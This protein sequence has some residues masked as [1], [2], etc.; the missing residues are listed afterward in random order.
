MPQYGFALM[1]GL[2]GGARGRG[3]HLGSQTTDIAERT[4]NVIT[5]C[6]REAEDR[7]KLMRNS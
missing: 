2:V 6:V 3:R 1:H 4:G 5:A 7:Q